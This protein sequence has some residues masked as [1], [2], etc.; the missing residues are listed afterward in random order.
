MNEEI[1]SGPKIGLIVGGI[2]V[3]LAIIALVVW[4]IWNFQFADKDTATTESTT[5]EETTTD[6]AV[7]E[8]TTT[9]DPT[10]D[11]K[12][13]QNDQQGYELRHP[14]NISV[15][16]APSGSAPEIAEK[17]TFFGTGNTTYFSVFRE[18]QSDPLADHAYF[19]DMNN[20]VRRSVNTTIASQSAYKVQTCEVGPPGNV[21]KDGKTTTDANVLTNPDGA[22]VSYGGY[23]YVLQRDR[24][25]ELSSEVFNQILSTL[26]FTN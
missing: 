12:T 25:S 8:D 10:A 16:S 17:Y 22:V 4:A 14:S 18:A 1:K 11:W 23:A 9:E 13:Y 26:V 21:C 6:D 5:V 19:V 2:I 15:I 7:A 3:G 24:G 20:I